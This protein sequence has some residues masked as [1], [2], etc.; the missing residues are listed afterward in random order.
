M[1]IDISYIFYQF[2]WICKKS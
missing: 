1:L 2:W